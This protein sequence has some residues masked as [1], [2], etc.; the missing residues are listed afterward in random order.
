MTFRHRDVLICATVIAALYLGWIQPAHGAADH[1]VA[2]PRGVPFQY[3]LQVNPS[4]SLRASGGINVNQCARPVLGGRCE[5]AR[6]FSIDLYALNGHTPNVA[7]VRAID[8]VGGYA[9]CYVNAGTWESWRPDAHAFAPS[10]LGRSNGWPGERWLDIRHA[11]SILAI[12]ERR[13]ALCERAGF[14]AVDF[15]NVDAFANDTGFAITAA[16]QLHFNRALA[17][18]AHQDHMAAGLKNDGD[19]ARTLEPL[20]DFAIDEQCIQY[21]SCTALAAFV[22]AGKPVYDVEYVG[23]PSWFCRSAPRG[24]DVTVKSMSLLDRPWRPCR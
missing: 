24:I 1:I 4:G 19:Q 15:D 9:I 10:L 2:P 12:M 14:S 21:H 8:R 3:Q 11:K 20:F 16:E 23:R 22:D 13:V 17:D 6:V 18:I 7:A 5:R